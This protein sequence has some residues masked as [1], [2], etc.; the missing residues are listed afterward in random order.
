[1][2]LSTDRVETA[3]HGDDPQEQQLASRILET[4]G[5]WRA[6]ESEHSALMGRVAHYGIAHKQML[7]LKQ[8]AF[9]LIHRKAL[10]EYLRL[11][12]VRGSTRMKILAHFHPVRGYSDSLVAEHGVYLRSACSYLCSKH[13]GGDIVQDPDFLDP[14]Q[15][16]ETLYAE[17]F[18]A[19][20]GTFFG[21]GR[22]EE[23]E[24]GGSLLPL[25][26]QQLDETRRAILDPQRHLPAYRREAELRRPTGDTQ[27]LDV[28]RLR[29]AISGLR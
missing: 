4:P 19:Y 28:Q 13:I 27:N 20:C 25:L 18:D 15:Q 17:Y 21:I 16:Y 11:R 3:L 24:T 14:I 2:Q 6:W 10:F 1:M 9:R 5:A 8:A 23:A 7:E 22:D 26:K 29:A 12:N